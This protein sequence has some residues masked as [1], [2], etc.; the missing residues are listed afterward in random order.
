MRRFCTAAAIV[1]CGLA[2]TG[3]PW[4]NDRL[5]FGG[6]IG[7]GFG[8]V[9]YV[10]VSPI[11]G[12]S[13]TEKLSVGGGITYRYRNDDRFAESLSTNDWPISVS[14]KLSRNLCSACSMARGL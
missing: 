14:R 8:D 2:V 4:A 9:D 7:F 11:V 12:Y 3:T 1:F 6:G 13:A 5:W 10:E